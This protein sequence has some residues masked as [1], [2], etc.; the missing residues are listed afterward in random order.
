VASA[1]DP[2]P[3]LRREPGFTY[4]PARTPSSLLEVV[5]VRQD[6]AQEQEWLPE[7]DPVDGA[8]TAVGLAMVQPLP[9]AASLGLPARARVVAFPVATPLLAALVAVD[10]QEGFRRRAARSTLVTI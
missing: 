7:S 4:G 9:T 8:L 2:A 6:P 10:R 3:A 1:I 5:T